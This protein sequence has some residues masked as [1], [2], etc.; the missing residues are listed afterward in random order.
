[1]RVIESTTMG[2]YTILVF[3][4][5]LPLTSWR[6]IVVDGV[7]YDTLPVMDAGDDCLAIPGAHDLTGKDAEFVA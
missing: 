1:M 7:R 5:P 6:A 3:S 2:P 4:A